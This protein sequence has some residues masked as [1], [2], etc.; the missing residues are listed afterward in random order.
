MERTGPLRRDFAPFIR[1]VVRTALDNMADEV[2]AGRRR[3]P[4]EWVT[5]TAKTE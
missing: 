3:M 5:G 1:E 2:E 4:I